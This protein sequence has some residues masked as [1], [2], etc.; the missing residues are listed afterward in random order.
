MHD[1][2]YRTTSKQLT[3]RGIIRMSNQPMAQIT[4][5]GLDG[6]GFPDDMSIRVYPIGP[7]E[8]IAEKLFFIDEDS[9]LQ[10]CQ[11]NTQDKPLDWWKAHCKRLDRAADIL[12]KTV[13]YPCSDFAGR[14]YEGKCKVTIDFSFLYIPK[15]STGRTHRDWG[16]PFVDSDGI[17]FAHILFYCDRATKHEALGGTD[18]AGLTYKSRSSRPGA[19]VLPLNWHAA[20]DGVKPD[21]NKGQREIDPDR[22]AAHEFIHG[23]GISDHDTES[24]LFGGKGSLNDNGNFSNY[25]ITAIARKAQDAA[26]THCSKKTNI[27]LCCKKMGGTTPGGSPTQSGDATPGGSPTQGGGATPPGHFGQSSGNGVFHHRS[28]SAAS[29]RGLAAYSGGAFRGY[30]TEDAA[31]LFASKA[32]NGSNG[33]KDILLVDYNKRCSCRSCSKCK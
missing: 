4:G 26:L 23:F 14:D 19:T 5:P 27:H 7:C 6:P 28:L 10:Y 22:V 8:I 16:T 25:A 32:L 15:K 33:E 30:V 12:R 2:Y 20:N 31:R 9:F 24:N 13:V 3:K 11:M 29:G 21:D 18:H 17:S 1:A